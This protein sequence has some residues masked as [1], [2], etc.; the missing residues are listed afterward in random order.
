MDC[1]EIRKQY[2]GICRN[3]EVD[4]TE[5]FGKCNCGNQVQPICGADGRT[6]LNPCFL[7]CLAGGK[8]VHWGECEHHNPKSCGCQ[9]YDHPICG[10]DY[11]TYKN[12]CALEC[13]KVQEHK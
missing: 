12:K 2:N 7:D 4:N 5:I 9:D 8:A 10:K 6:Y 3:Y 11:K 1:A 13:M